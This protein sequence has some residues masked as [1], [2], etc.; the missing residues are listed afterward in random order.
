MDLSHLN[1]LVE[2]A[3]CGSITKAAQRLFITQ[4]YVSR[5][6][7]EIEE[8]LKVKIFIRTRQGVV[9]TKKGEKI[10]SDSRKIIKDYQELFESSNNSTDIKN[11]F[12]LTTVRSSLVMESFIC[13]LNEYSDEDISSF[14]IKESEANIPI[15]DVHFLNSDLGVIYAMED[16]KET[17]IKEFKRKSIEYKKICNLKPCIIV[18]TNHP[19]IENKNTEEVS[20]EDLYKYGLVEYGDIY[21]PY[22]NELE[23]SNYY[24][25]ILDIKKMKRTIT[26]SD[27]GSLHNIL[28]HTNFISLGTQAA[29]NQEE[30]FNIVSIPIKSNDNIS[31]LEMGVIYQKNIELSSVAKRFIEVLL[32]NYT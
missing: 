26:V 5:V 16:S 25:K 32:D 22:D 8:E 24:E 7:K 14:N 17:L 15:Q 29:K 20:V 6:I 3:N 2:V 31:R 21:L 11:S 30:M 4:P 10:I 12:S 1:Y 28:I 9:L 27:R 19:L 23:I 18:R 13:L